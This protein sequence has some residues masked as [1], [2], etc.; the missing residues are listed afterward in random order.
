[1][2]EERILALDVSSKTGWASMVSTDNGIILEA[3]G[4]VPQIHE[5]EGCYPNT[6]VDWACLIF[7][8]IEELIIKYRPD[9][10]AIE[11]TC[12]GSKSVYSQKIL[13]FCH[14]MLASF[15]KESNMKVMY[16][17]T[18]EWRNLVGCKMTAE[19]SKHNK[20]V[21]EYKKK[22]KTKVAYNEEGKRIGIKTKK[23][24]NIRRANEIFGKWLKE[25]LQKKNED[26]ADALLLGFCYHIKRLDY[27]RRKSLG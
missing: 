3:H 2:I 9:V 12:A 4:I 7:E 20:A 6:Y 16:L 19:E 27:E 22:N 23:H 26:E 14:F 5:P 8:K 18:G 11:E 15:I 13:E 24:V 17:L 1:M 21:R 25:P 10:L